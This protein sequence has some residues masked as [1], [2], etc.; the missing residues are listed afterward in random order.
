MI[1]AIAITTGSIVAG[2]AIGSVSRRQSPWMG[3]LRTFAV[4]AVATAVIVQL[5]PESVHEIG[6]GALLVFVAAL[7]LPGLLAPLAR[8]LRVRSEL[9]AHEVG[10]ELAFFG[11]VAHQLAEGLALGTYAGDGHAG[12]A[13][14]SLVLAVAAHTLPLTALF[15]AEALAHRSRRGA[16]LRTAVIIGATLA[17]FGLADVVHER[18]QVELHTWGSAGIAGFLVHVIFHHDAMPSA[19]RGLSVSALDVLAVALGVGL[20]LLAAAQGGEHGAGVRA[21]IGEAFVELLME[22]APMLL[23]GLALGAVLQIVGSRIPSRYYT[24][25]G[26]WTQALRGIA[27]G[28][29]LPL[30]ACGV[31]PIAES[32]RKRGAGPALV[33]AFLIATPE[34][35]PETLTLTVR[36]LGWPFAIVRLLA[37]VGL[38]LFVAVVFARLVDRGQRSAPS[39]DPG[40]TL[41]SGAAAHGRTLSRVYGYFDELVLHTAPWTF[42]GLLAAAFVQAV[43]G[44]G[45]LS[46]LADAGLDVPV[47]AAV[48]MPSYVCAA[49]ATPLAAVLLLKGVSPG[50]VLVGLLLGPA[51]NLATIGVLKR[52]YG[53]RAVLLGV[54]FT[55]VLSMALG[56]AV[57]LAGLTATVPAQLH[58]EHG[59]GVFTVG[60]VVILALVLL[61][62]LWRW[63]LRPWLEIIEGSHDHDHGHGHHHHGHHDHHH[64]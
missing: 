25:G 23:L 44:E 27:V 22:T 51:T 18:V 1:E 58:E 20:P 8:R 34:L 28:A 61:A 10:T 32:L 14:E 6:G 41:V 9:S 59:H 45:S 24:S 30:C 37:A 36:L 15:V 3:P 57:N 21:Q 16:W 42:V 64:H 60:A 52:G 63:G 13:H 40:E 39:V 12:H 35:G 19:R 17:G 55:L 31:L 43:L 62:Q 50:A 29:P 4:A 46:S 56:Y 54:G 47:V 33:M 2:A 7:A 49:S 53:A 26:R 38:A 48:A 11:F 5:L